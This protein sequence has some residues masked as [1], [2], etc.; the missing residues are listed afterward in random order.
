MKKIIITLVATL[1][2]AATLTAGNVPVKILDNNPDQFTQF[3]DVSIVMDFRMS[4]ILLEQYNPNMSDYGTSIGLGLSYKWR[5]KGL[6]GLSFAADI[7]PYSI[8][9]PLSSAESTVQAWDF[10]LDGTLLFQVYNKTKKGFSKVIVRSISF[11]NYTLNYYISVPKVKY[12]DVVSIRVGGIAE[13]NNLASS[14]GLTDKFQQKYLIYAGIDWFT[15]QSLTIDILDEGVAE[16]YGKRHRKFGHMNLYGDLIF[17]TVAWDVGGRIGLHSTYYKYL[18][19]LLE[20]GYVT[21]KGFYWKV[22]FGANFAFSNG[23]K[24]KA[25]DKDGWNNKN[26]KKTYEM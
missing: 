8:M 1:L 24:D 18:S 22:S 16:R 6:I 11:G 9:S 25:K 14:L 26:K 21:N 3:L 23:E 2:F 15:L 17:D 10:L 5:P 19:T 12:R 7:A 4:G 20:I 13:Y